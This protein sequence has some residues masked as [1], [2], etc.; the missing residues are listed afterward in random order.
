[1]T[2]STK[3]I[4][5]TGNIA[6]GKSVV[7]RMLS[8]AG[9][10][11]IDADQIAHRLVY[12]EGPAYEAVI[13]AF[14]EAVLAEDGTISRSKLGALVFN[15]PAKLA[16]LESLLHPLVTQSIQMRLRRTR[17]PLAAVEA[18]KLLEAGLGEICA[19]VWVSHAAESVQM[20]RLLHTRHMH[21]DEA[22]RRIAL[23]PPQSEKLAQADVVINTEGVF[24]HTWNQIMQALNDTIQSGTEDGP[25]A[26]QVPREAL[27][28]FWNLHSGENAAALYQHL[29]MRMVLPLWQA[30]H[31]AAL[32]LW[33]NWHFTATLSRLVLPEGAAPPADLLA[34]FEAQAQ[35]QQCEILLI[36]AAAASAHR[37]ALAES[38]Y[39]PWAPDTKTYPAWREA[40]QRATAPGQAAPWV[41]VLSELFEGKACFNHQ[42]GSLV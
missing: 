39:T 26:V 17:Q 4:G 19:A 40:A 28:G 42:Q 25:S 13:A 27:E 21:E 11:G 5:I 12:P 29:G 38:G 9:V 31:L 10:L 36:P 24:Q 1:M 16:H 2:E 15:D 30:G 14:G 23:Q 18:I 7:R 8:N 32:A 33:E 6:T 3:L 22:R 20:E 37:L 35:A 34:A 41:R